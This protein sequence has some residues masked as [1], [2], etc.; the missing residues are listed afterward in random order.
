LPGV[1][2]PA[3]LQADAELLCGAV[4]EAGAL[5]VELS[6]Q[7]VRHWTK[8]DGSVVTE[9]DLQIDAFLKARLHGAR[10]DYGWLSEETP[11]SEHRLSC[12]RLW[13]VDPIDGTQSFVNGGDG[14]CIGAALV[15]NG[16]PIL[17]AL[18]RPAA[19]EFYFAAAGGGAY[20]NQNRIR[21]N[22]DTLLSGATLMG[23]GKALKVLS[24][25]GVAASNA[26]HIPLLLRLAFVASGRID[27]ALSI[28]NKNDWDLAAGDLL[29]EEAGAC[30][31]TIDGAQM[32]YNKPQPWQNGMVAA[33]INRHRAVMAQLEK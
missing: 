21:P 19:D 7:K 32:M 10:P 25:Y 24:P 18:F 20:C 12:Q 2:V 16:R 15:E 9:A 29:M 14:W 8:K 13:I 33:G 31:T 11:D 5:G 1:D 26:P 28:G 27:I 17:S 22:D 30:L 3:H 4:R 23:T 6:K